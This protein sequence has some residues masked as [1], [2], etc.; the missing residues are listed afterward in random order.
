LVV[1]NLA[2]KYGVN[3]A[4]VA[5]VGGGLVGAALAYGIAKSGRSVVLLDEADQAFRAA[6]G[7]FGLVWVQSKGYQF[8]PYATWTRQSGL[9]WPTLARDL[10]DETGVNVQLDQTGA[11][12]LCFSDGEI[13]ERIKRLEWVR[14]AIGGNYPFEILGQAEL[15]RRLPQIGPEVTGAAYSPMDGQVNPLKLLRALHAA[16]RARGV[17]IRPDHRVSAIDYTEGRFK[18]KTATSVVTVNRVVL[19]AGLGNRELGEQVGLTASV[20]P[21]RGQILITE[22][23]QKVLPCATAFIRQTDEGT[24][25]IGDSMEDV[26]FNDATDPD[27]LKT[28]ARSAIRSF[29]F[30]A[31]LKLVRAWSALRVMSPDGY[32]I[33]QSSASCPGAFLVT[34][35]SGVTLAAVHAL[36][37]AQWI[38]DDVALPDIEP[39]SNARF[40]T[41]DAGAGHAH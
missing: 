4:D 30:I 25:Q 13:A 6:R 31:Q 24:I 11:Y 2:H 41:P 29:P 20:R 17:S 39:F 36:R 1:R 33:Y 28:I 21:I 8:A 9:L 12:H 7:N 16:C 22:R 35:H 14:E 15:K 38:C 34:C 23:V 19:A 10:N 5:I 37:L 32:P 27:V 40:T 18:I 26:G 3:T